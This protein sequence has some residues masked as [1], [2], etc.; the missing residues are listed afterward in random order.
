MLF[1]VFL[2][3]ILPQGKQVKVNKKRALMRKWY[4]VCSL[5]NEEHSEGWMDGLMLFSISAVHDK[6]VSTDTPIIQEY[7]YLPLLSYKTTKV[8]LYTYV[9]AKPLDLWI[10]PVLWIWCK[11]NPPLNSLMH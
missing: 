9:K 4:A 2:S 11:L 5:T 6:S 3:I 8:S 10:T 7:E 1:D